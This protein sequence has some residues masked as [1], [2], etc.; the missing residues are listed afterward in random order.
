MSDHN[1]PVEMSHE[2]VL[3]L[4]LDILKREHRDLD[5]AIHA[6]E[7]SQRADPLTLRRL[8]KQKLVLKDRISALEDEIT[9]DI[10]A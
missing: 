1:A 7:E 9:P 3:R 8:K 10:I 2:E 4:R 5:Q 6:L